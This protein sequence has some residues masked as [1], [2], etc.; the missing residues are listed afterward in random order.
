MHRDDLLKDH[1]K[2][3]QDAGTIFVCTWHP[4]IR[5]LPRI[6][7]KITILLKTMNF[8]VENDVNL[9]KKIPSKP[10]VAFRRKKQLLRQK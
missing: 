1:G 3:I 5:S 8:L 2:N 4:S 10:I 7:V 6:Q 9:I